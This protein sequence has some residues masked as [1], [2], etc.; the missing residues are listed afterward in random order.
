MPKSLI[1]CGRTFTAGELELMRQTAME[2]S[3]LGVTEISR[4]VCELLRAIMSLPKEARRSRK[5]SGPRRR[6][7]NGS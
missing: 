6:S 5:T 3:A 2:F 4:T 1:F 7:R